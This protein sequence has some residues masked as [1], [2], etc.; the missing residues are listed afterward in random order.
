MLALLLLI[1]GQTTSKK[2]H[3]MQSVDWNCRP[4]VAQILRTLALIAC[5]SRLFFGQGPVVCNAQTK[6]NVLTYHNDLARTGQNLNETMLTPANVNTNSFGKLFTY[7]VDGY[8]YAQP[9]YMAGVSIPGKGIH[10]VVFVATEHDSVY[11]FDADSNQGDNAAPLWQVSF[12]DPAAG[13]TAMPLS[14]VGL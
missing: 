14:D 7:P 11:A 13:I 8:F 1:F 3:R 12:I 6:P 10:N 9:L 5:S 4:K 2:G